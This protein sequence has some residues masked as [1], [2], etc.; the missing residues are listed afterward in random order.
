MFSVDAASVVSLVDVC[1]CCCCCCCCC[2]FCFRRPLFG[3]FRN[4]PRQ[5]G[6][7]TSV[8]NQT[9]HSQLHPMICV[10][11]KGSHPCKR[12]AISLSNCNVR[13]KS[14]RVWP[15]ARGYQLPKNETTNYIIFN[16]GG[17]L[18]LVAFT[19]VLRRR[20]GTLTRACPAPS[21]RREG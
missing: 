4:H 11:T 9:A 2:S 13:S 3:A 1:C 15:R 17:F 7:G 18:V 8:K 16:V 19:S 10:S 14:R 6:T 20:A 5:L 21:R 12:T